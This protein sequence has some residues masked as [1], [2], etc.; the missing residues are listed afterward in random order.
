M[1][2]FRKFFWKLFS[3][4]IFVF[5][6]FFYIGHG[7]ILLLFGLA[8]IMLEDKFGK[9]DLGEIGNIFFGG[10]YII[11]G[12]GTYFF[13]IIFFKSTYFFPCKW[14]YSHMYC[15]ILIS[16]AQVSFE[17]LCFKK[18]KQNILLFAFCGKNTWPK[19]NFFFRFSSY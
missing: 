12:M 4:I 16:F 13:L 3:R 5:L 17:L 14:C 15:E 1:K 7:T 8:M 18:Y 11:T 19:L 10:R 2:I 9:K 6:L